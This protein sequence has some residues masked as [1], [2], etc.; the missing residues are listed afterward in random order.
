MSQC[1]ILRKF[2]NFNINNDDLLKKKLYQ[3]EKILM[4]F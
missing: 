2:K 3:N 4:I 1:F